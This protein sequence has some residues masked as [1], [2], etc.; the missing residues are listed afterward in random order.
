MWSQTHEFW[1]LSSQENTRTSLAFLDF[2]Q[3]DLPRIAGMPSIDLVG[4]A[5][6]SDS[7]ARTDKQDFRVFDFCFNF[8]FFCENPEACTSRRWGGSRSERRGRNSARGR[9]RRV[10]GPAQAG[11][12]GKP[13][14]EARVQDV[15]KYSDPLNK[16]FQ[17]PTNCVMPMPRRKWMQW[18]V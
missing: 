11:V 1:R 3:F 5:D 8:D 16:L 9:S 10:R 2:P 4:V 13:G 12:G 18:I 15:F 7:A 17:A 6:L 14:F